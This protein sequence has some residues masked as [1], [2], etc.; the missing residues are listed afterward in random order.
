MLF[1]YGFRGCSSVGEGLWMEHG[2]YQVMNDAEGIRPAPYSWNRV[3][4]VLYIE[5]P[6]GV[7]FSYSG[8]KSDY[9]TNGDDKETHDLYASLQQFLL[10]FPQFA[11]SPLYLSGE[12]YAGECTYGF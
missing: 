8:D 6:V 5:H 11:K 1:L 2:P 7:G 4:N 3:A 12:S 9:K 10:R